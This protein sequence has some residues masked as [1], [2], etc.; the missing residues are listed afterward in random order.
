LGEN[1][2]IKFLVTPVEIVVEGGRVRALRCIRLELGEPDD[3]GRRKPLPIPGSEFDVEAD[4]AIVAIGQTPQLSFLDGS[5]IEVAPEHRI[6]STPETLATNLP[7]VF[8]AGDAQSGPTT[9]IQAVAAGKKAAI[10][11]NAL[12]TGSETL[13]SPKSERVV[14]YEALNTSYF[15]HEPRQELETADMTEYKNIA[16]TEA[17]RCFQCGSCTAC[18][19]CWFLCPDAVILPKKMEIQIDY[20]YCKGCGICVEE[21]PRA[22]LMI[23]EESKWQ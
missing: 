10:G 4:M 22:A 13:E 5:G 11:I 6:H 7:N 2:E 14:R 20:D 23:E 17:L 19:T 1:I 21:C 3:T 18:N 8:V 9:V 15:K 12:L 16:I